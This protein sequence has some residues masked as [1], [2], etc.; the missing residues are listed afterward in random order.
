MVFLRLA[1][2]FERDAERGDDVENCD[3]DTS[4]EVDAIGCGRAW[5]SGRRVDAIVGRDIA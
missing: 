5:N 4:E 3:S 2:C 1:F